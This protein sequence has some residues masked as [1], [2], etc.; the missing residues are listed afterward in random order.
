MKLLFV[1][2]SLRPNATHK[3]LPVGLGYVITSVQEAGFDFDLLDID[4]NAYDD[5]TVERYIRN[6]R[7][8][9]VALGSIV[10][11][12][13]WIKWFTK[14]VRK[15]QPYCK[16]ILGNSVGSSIPDL[17]MNNMPVDV[18]VTGEGDITTVEV[19]RAFKDGQRLIPLPEDSKHNKV[20]QLMKIGKQVK[21]N[22]YMFMT[23]MIQ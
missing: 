8:D 11:H 15:Y 2:P 22:F 23:S 5:D 16:I 9:V 18:V 14:T 13:K 4:V 1:N 12:Y 3:Y 7:Y 21:V 19:L 10:T 20:G 17:A 6:N